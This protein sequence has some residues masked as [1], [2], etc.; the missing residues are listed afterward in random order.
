[1][2]ESLSLAVVLRHHATPD[3]ILIVGGAPSNHPRN[4]PSN[5][6]SDERNG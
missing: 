4:H 2:S 1:M 5:D 6:P 3:L